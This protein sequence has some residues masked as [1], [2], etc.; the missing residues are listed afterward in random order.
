VAERPEDKLR[1]IYQKYLY[2]IQ[3]KT[4]KRINILTIVQAIFVPLTFLAGIYGM[5]FIGIPELEW[6]HGYLYAWMLMIL[7]AGIEIYIFFRKGW[8]D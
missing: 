4:N 6:E 5:N 3:E 2:E 7:I 1:D 8:F